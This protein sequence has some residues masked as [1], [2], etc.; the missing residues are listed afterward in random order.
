[1]AR[2]SRFRKSTPEASQAEI[3]PDS[4]LRRFIARE[5]WS[6]LQALL[7]VAAGLWV[8]WPAMHGRWIGDDRWYIVDNPLMNDP[9]R[10][11]KAWFKL[12]SWVEYYPMEET[13]QWVQWQLWHTETFGYH[14]T[15]V[16]LH[17]VSGLL[18]WRLFSKLGLRLAWL[19]GLIF[20]VHPMMVDSVALINELKTSLSMPPFLLALCAWIDYEEK[21]KGRDYWL[22][23]GL[24]VVAMLCKI[25]M[26][27]FPVIILLYAWWKRGRIGWRDLR[28]SL[29]FFAIS[30]ALGLATIH[31]GEIYYQDDPAVNR[32]V[33]KEDALTRFV[34]SGE[35]I[36]FYFSRC[37]LPIT[38]MAIY[39]QWRVDPSSPL[40]YLPWLVLVG[41]ICQLW[42]MRK[43]WG[44]HALLG[45]GFFLIMLGPFMGF[46]WISYM[47]ATWI[48]EHLLYIPILGLIGL[49]VAG[50]EEVGRQVPGSA[51]LIGAGILTIGIGSL[52]VVSH[53]YAATFQDQATL[54]AYNLRYNPNSPGLHNTLGVGLWDLKRD[55]EAKEQFETALRLDPNTPDARQNLGNTLLRL[56][57]VTEAIEQYQ[58]LV[59]LRPDL[60]QAHVSLGDGLMEVG[61][62]DEAIAQYKEAVKLEPNS[63]WM[64]FNLGLILRHD[65][66]I[67]EAIDEY[68]KALAIYPNYAEA[69]NSLGIA[70][71]HQGNMIEAREEFQRALAANPGCA[72]ARDNLQLVE[73]LQINP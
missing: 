72:D 42:T 17:L 36:A 69:H 23:L 40:P 8:F 33:P 2:R 53:G 5:K 24:F 70:L 9:A 31:A 45:L 60:S 11:W 56:G 41:T 52:A 73:K 10:I 12:G 25:T 27:M 1:M 29:L 54:A 26:A 49:V 34:L 55:A 38:P 19:G 18:I 43:T 3:D 28:N 48:L 62:V 51:R 14:L 47:N 61:R 58:I 4:R 65:N 32:I 7:I 21:K 35:T 30:F 50:L 44:R 37:F 57:H 66:Q 13:V 46:E 6:V 67:P 68:R 16:I 15:N 64:H 20:V 71:Y 39:P 63:A 59:H 22:A